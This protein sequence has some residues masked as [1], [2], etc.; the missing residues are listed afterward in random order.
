MNRPGP[1]AFRFLIIP[2][3][4]RIDM[5][6]HEVLDACAKLRAPFAL[7]NVHGFKSR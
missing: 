7:G 5:L 2:A 3:L 4:I 1:E 6:G